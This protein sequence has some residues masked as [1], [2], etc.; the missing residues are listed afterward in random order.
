MSTEIRHN[1]FRFATSEL[2]HSAF[3]AWILQSAEAAD[4]QILEGPREAGLRLLRALGL[5][6]T[7][8]SVEVK[9][10]VPLPSSGRV[11]IR[12]VV[13]NTVLVVIE[14]KV[15]ALPYKE[16]LERYKH[17]L[18]DNPQTVVP[19][20]ISCAFDR[21]VRQGIEKAGVWH[22]LGAD[23]LLELVEPESGR[24]PL[25]DDYI[26]WLRKTIA[27]RDALR[28]KA[29]SSSYADIEDALGTREGQWEFLESAVRG[30][31]GEFSLGTNRGGRPWTQFWFC[32]AQ[33]DAD[34]L[35]WRVDVGGRGP[36]L[37]FRQY[38][39]EPRPTTDAKME[40]RDKLRRI[41]NQVV[42][43]LEPGFVVAKPGNRGTYESEVGVLLLRDNPPSRII[44]QLPRVHQE[45]VRRLG[46]HGLCPME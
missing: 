5:D 23:E 29:C 31:Q 32:N 21:H 1:L 24:H 25:L 11:D 16:Q 42:D 33:D 30:L 2:S 36:Y 41:W 45:L 4:S 43:D 13:D 44:E 28:T 15:S 6:N 8:R 39:S 34:G 10:E 40:R 14:N 9:T 38:Q 46:E 35:F 12:S 3:W 18:S 26:E 20:I 22:Y 37:A 7:P 27:D 17:S 19:A